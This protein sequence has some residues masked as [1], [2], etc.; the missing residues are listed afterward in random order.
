MDTVWTGKQS[1]MMM[2]NVVF[3]TT[4]VLMLGMQ[5]T[6]RLTDCVMGYQQ[7]LERRLVGA[8]VSSC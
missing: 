6:I 4:R 5:L 8:Q 2:H 7:Q 1:C 3:L